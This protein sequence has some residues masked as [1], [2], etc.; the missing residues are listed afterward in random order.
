M[1][2]GAVYTVPAKND[3][4]A[5]R[6][7]RT[8]KKGSAPPIVVYPHIRVAKKY[9]TQSRAK[10]EK[11]KEKMKM[12]EKAPSNR[13]SKEHTRRSPPVLYALHPFRQQGARGLVGVDA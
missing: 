6:D 11:K 4:E 8:K 10:N 2:L 3:S 5:R 7:G 13:R 9:S 1:N 12:K